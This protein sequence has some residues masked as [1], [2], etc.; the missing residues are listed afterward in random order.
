MRG[1]RIEQFVP[2]WRRARASTL[3]GGACGCAPIG[4]TDVL[5]QRV[6]LRKVD[7]AV[8]GHRDRVEPG[9]ADRDRV[10]GL[11]RRGWR[12]SA[13]TA[14]PR[15][16]APARSRI[17]AGERRRGS[18]RR[19]RRPGRRRSSAWWRRGSLSKPVVVAKSRPVRW[20]S[21]VGSA[22]TAADIVARSAPGCASTCQS[23][24]TV[25]MARAVIV[26]FEA[27]RKAPSDAS[28]PT[29]RA[30]PI[31]VAASR[32][33]T[34]ANQPSQPTDRDGER[35]GG[36][37]VRRRAHASAS[38][39]RS[40]RSV[41]SRR[42][43][44]SSWRSRWAATAGSWVL[45][46]SAA[47]AP[48]A[49]EQRVDHDGAG[50]L[51]ELAGRFVGEEQ[52]V[53]AGDGPGDGD[54]LRLAAGQ[55]VRELAREARRA[56]AGR[57]RPCAVAAAAAG[58]R[59]AG[60]AG[61]ATFS[62]TSSAGIRLGAWNTTADRARAQCRPGA[63]RRPLDGAGRRG[64]RARRE[65]HQRGLARPGR[66][67]EGD[68]VAGADLERG[69]VDGDDRLRAGVERPGETAG[70]HDRQRSCRRCRV[71]RGPA[72]SAETTA[73]IP[74]PDR[75]RAERS[76]RRWPRATGRGWRRSRPHRSRAADA[77][78][79]GS[80]ARG[81]FVELAGRLVGQHDRG[82]L[83]SATARP[84][85]AA[86]PP[87]RV[88]AGDGARGRSSPTASS[89]SAMR[90]R[91]TRPASC[92]ASRTLP[93]T[94]RWSTRLPLWNSTP[95][96]R[97]RSAARTRSGRRVIG[98]PAMRTWPPS[99]SS[100]PARQA[101]SVDL[102][103]PEGPVTATSLAAVRPAATRRRRARVSSSP[104]WKKRYRSTAS[105]G[106]AVG[107]GHVHVS[108]SRDDRHG[109]TLSAPLA[110]DSVRI[111]TVRVVEEHVALDATAPSSARSP[112]SARC[113]SRRSPGR[114]R[115]PS[116]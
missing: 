60:A 59:P 26:A 51:V 53:P 98:S 50:G 75:R 34:S 108:E 78:A 46:T 14:A 88:E 105:T 83:A 64:R 39:L 9:A 22:A 17:S 102:P 18:R 61:R 31:A 36:P 103:D 8:D 58:R 35:A 96:I 69:A 65:V 87:D 15:V 85:R 44:S 55:L 38:S 32:P 11:R 10:A 113:R 95:I 107:L 47:S 16:D 111:A 114:R 76:G 93:A 23:T 80:R 41:T 110:P 100:R 27:E 12:R 52:A 43:A 84:A 7:D 30:M 71:T 91:S 63:D 104:A 86:S 81:Q 20:R 29:A 109:S 2:R 13:G 62:M 66:P 82:S 33:R 90:S 92:C 115:R 68:A 19:S 42:R 57:A 24:A 6:G 73:L 79:P 94:V 67:D 45:T 70:P 106:A 89:S 56:R 25:S 97:A 4:R 72:Q 54:T 28:S 99:G 1:E 112:G 49:V 116:G 48:V 37:R 77:A 21:T 74:P 101:S 40:W 3:S 5:E